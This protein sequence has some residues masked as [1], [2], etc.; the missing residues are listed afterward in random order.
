MDYPTHQM[1]YG[2]R[3]CFYWISVCLFFQ[4][5]GN[6]LGKCNNKRAEWIVLLRFLFHMRFFFSSF[7]FILS[8]FQT[9]S[10]FPFLCQLKTISDSDHGFCWWLMAWVRKIL[11]NFLFIIKSS[12]ENTSRHVIELLKF[13]DRIS[14]KND[15]V[16]WIRRLYEQF[17]VLFLW[18]FLTD[19]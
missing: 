16:A 10:L 4:I 12:S 15:N 3:P 13:W 14:T 17:I 7:S 9:L 6:K 2:V 11:V 5:S 19:P 18:Y 1:I 8:W